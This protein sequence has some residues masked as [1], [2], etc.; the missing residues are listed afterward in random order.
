VWAAVESSGTLVEVNAAT[1]GVVRRVRTGG[2]PHNMTV[3]P[4]GTV[5]AGLYASNGI[6]IVRDGRLNTVTLGG[7][8]H[9]VKISGGRIVVAN[10]G[11]GRLDLVSLAGRLQGRI[12]LAADPHDLAIAPGGQVA[13]VT[14]DGDD[15]LAVANLRTRTVRY[16]RTGHSPHDLL[17]APDGR[18]FVTDWNGAVY[19]FSPSGVELDGR[20]LGREAHHLAFSADG[21]QVWITDNALRVIFVLDTRTLRIIAHLPTP[22]APHHVAITTDGRLA[23]VADNSD[24]TLLV[25]RVSTR[26]LVRTIRVGAGPHGVWAVS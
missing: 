26:R 22:G 23:V 24:G 21:G 6:A 9:D 13:W 12:P 15:R 17:F 4:D 2:G 8:P 25:Y 20:S 14:L 10:E 19:V 16:V 3:G 18:L 7:R 11:A 1:G 5:V